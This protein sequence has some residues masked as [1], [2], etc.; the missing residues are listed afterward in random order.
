ME[1]QFITTKDGSH[2]IVI[3]E[4]LVTYHSVHGAIRESRHVFIEAGLNFLLKSSATQP[5]RIFEMGFGTGLNAFLTAIEIEKQQTETFYTAV[6]LFPL[7]TEETE[8]LNYPGL[9]QQ[10]DLFQ[11]IH[12]CNW[13]QNVAITKYFTIRKEKT[14]LVNY[15]TGR[16]FH[17]VYYD[18]FAPQ[19]QPELWT[20]EIFEKLFRMLAPGGVL[21]TYCSKGDV[22]RAMTA[23]GFDVKKLP[24][25]P[26]KREMLRA[27]SPQS[28]PPK[29]ERE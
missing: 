22:R 29:M 18:A 13:Q 27:T 17:L 12:E 11:K 10:K 21:V 19:A 6:E 26:G 5:L 24:G 3:P 28:S 15:S 4:L 2:S 8:S 23:A 25:P 9:L 1:R 7:S 16:Q 14:D 20:K